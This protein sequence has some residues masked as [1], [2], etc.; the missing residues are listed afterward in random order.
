MTASVIARILDDPDALAD[1]LGKDETAVGREIYRRF[2]LGIAPGGT[3][4]D[5]DRVLLDGVR[6]RLA[7]RRRPSSGWA[8][9]SALAGGRLVVRRD[10]GLEVAVAF[11]DIERAEGE[12]VTLRLP[13]LEPGVMNGWVWFHGRTRGRDKLTARIYLCLPTAERAKWW[14]DLVAGLDDQAHVFSAK[15]IR[16]RE[17]RVRPD[18]AVIYCRTP[19]VPDTLSVVRKL[20]PPGQLG[21]PTAGFAAPVCAGISVGVPQDGEDPHASLGMERAMSIARLLGSDPPTESDLSAVAELLER[22]RS[23]VTGLLKECA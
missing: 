16:R 11:G 7:G 6:R 20:V 13:S 4:S 1:L 5:D 21:S 12:Q 10:D 8:Y 23:Q 9:R 2:H 15:I 19:D 22:Q 18:G 14:S 17:E 3:G